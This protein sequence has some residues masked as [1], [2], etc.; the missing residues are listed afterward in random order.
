[1]AAITCDFSFLHPIAPHSQLLIACLLVVGVIS[2]PP[3]VGYNYQLPKTDLHT[4]FRAPS[5]N[6]LPPSTGYSA[7]SSNYLPPTFNSN[8][9]RE[10]HN[11]DHGFPDTH[12]HENQVPKSYEF[13]YSVKDAHSGNDYNR[14]ESSD[15]NVVRGEYRVQLPDGR[16]QIVTYHAD[17]Q[18]GFHAEVRYEGD[19]KYP[20]LNTNQ[21]GYNY[22]PPNYTGSLTGFNQQTRYKPSTVYGP[23]GFH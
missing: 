16:T 15:G 7:P 2:E 19:A 18:T 8:P 10:S 23:T 22:D 11:Q 17:W 6:Y 12:G 20:D 13:G 3:S 21:H 14:R 9:R 1:M 5:R 4:N